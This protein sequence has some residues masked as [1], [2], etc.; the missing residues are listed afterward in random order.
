MRQQPKARTTSRI[1]QTTIAPGINNTKKKDR[2]AVSIQPK[3]KY[4]LD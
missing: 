3:I 2:I 4:S 1:K